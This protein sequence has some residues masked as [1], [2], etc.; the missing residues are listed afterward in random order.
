MELCRWSLEEYYRDI[1]W[2]YVGRLDP[3]PTS[4]VERAPRMR[5]I[6]NIMKQIVEGVNYIHFKGYI[7]RD[8]KPVNG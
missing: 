2:S 5:D 1:M 7:H 6:W 3:D 8:L 4:P